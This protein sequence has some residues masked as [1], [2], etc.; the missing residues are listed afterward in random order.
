VGRKPASRRRAVKSGLVPD[1]V[2]PICKQP[3]AA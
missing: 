2:T 3:K 1:I